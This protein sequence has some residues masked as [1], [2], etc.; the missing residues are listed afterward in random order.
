MQ[1]IPKKFEL[2]HKGQEFLRARSLEAIER[3]ENLSRHVALIEK[4]MDV[5]NLFSMNPAGNE[6]EDAKAC[7][8]LGMRLFNGCAG[9]FQLIVSGYYQNAAMLLRDL[10]ETVFLIGY[11]QHEPDKIGIWRAGDEKARRKAFGPAKIRK[12]LDKRDGFTSG[13]RKAAYDLLCQLAVHPTFEGLRMLMPARRQHH[14]GPFFDPT[15][16]KAMIEELAKLAIQAG[17][18]YNLFF[19]PD[20]KQRMVVKLAF[21][22]ASMEWRE[23]YFGQAFDREAIDALKQQVDQLR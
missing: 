17:T 21:L 8:L 12:S 7:R 19:K 14:C 2:L 5:L 1:P 9:A 6:T 18:N 10:L 11:L 22:E 4:S 13:K 16:L 15:A 20:T 23:I 3:D